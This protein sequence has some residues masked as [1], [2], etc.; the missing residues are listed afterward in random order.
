VADF[1]SEDVLARQ[2]GDVIDFFLRTCLLDELTAS[3][4]DALI[5]RSGASAMFA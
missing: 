3:L 2:S 5:G 4:C 1:L